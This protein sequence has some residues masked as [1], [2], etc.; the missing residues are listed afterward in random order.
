ME[1]QKLKM[2]E[3]KL[4]ILYDHYKDTFENI[5]AYIQRRNI[6][7]ISSIVLVGFL[8][9][10]LVSPNVSSDVS[11]ALI[12]ENI[13]EVKIDYSLISSI[14]LFVLM[15][16]VLLYYQINFLIEKMYAYLHKVEEDLTMALN[17]FEIGREGKNYLNNYPILS[18]VA[19]RIYTLL[20][21][22]SILGIA[23]S[24]WISEK[25]KFG[26]NWQN[27]H[28][29]FDTLILFLIVL[30]S[31]LYLSNRHFNDFKSKESE[32]DKEEEENKVSKS[33]NKNKR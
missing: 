25:N 26:A 7:T 18:S 19:H 29:M 31:L 6:Y 3:K 2:D 14:I 17:P 4:E 9:I 13:G 15:W 33:K 1:E 27:G 10:E 16:S 32:K 30:L 23:I 12:K 22:I 20:F 21:P 24:K 28:F 11:I 5:K 8:S